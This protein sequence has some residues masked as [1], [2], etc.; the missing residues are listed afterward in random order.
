VLSVGAY[1]AAPGSAD[2]ERIALVDVDVAGARTPVPLPAD[3]DLYLVNDD[4]LTFA[5]QRLDAGGRQALVRAAAALPTS[6]SRGVAVA[7]VWDQLVKGEL[8][9]ED[10][11]RC[12]TAV[13]ARETGD[14]VVEPYL[15]LAV[16][17]A[18]LWAPEARSGDLAALVAATSRSLAADPGRRQVA[19]RALARC[20]T[21]TDDIAWLQEQAGDDIDLQWRAL[22]REAELGGD[23]VD[24]MQRLLLADPNPDAWLR[25]LTVRA[26][27]PS[28]EEKEAVWQKVA[29][30]GAVPIGVVGS[31]MAAFWCPGQEEVVAPYA[32]RYLALM[33]QF[34]RGGMIPAMVLTNR[35][36]PLYAIEEEYVDAALA[37]SADAAAVV[38]K[39]LSER[40]DL[41]RRMLRARTLK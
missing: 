29:V 37:A 11:V 26:A 41:V 28:A 30:D 22:T 9:A 14:S 35:L 2:L 24:A 5:V 13:L 15:G 3:A 20:A 34:D 7:T 6:I 8:T 1:R 18:E 4:D 32:E 23:V 27:M 38:R 33:P 10:T 39:Q 40:S 16:D 36:F 21:S 25:A 17:A 31:V 19:L 12:L